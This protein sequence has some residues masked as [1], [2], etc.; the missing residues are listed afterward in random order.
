MPWNFRAG[1][2]WLFGFSLSPR[3]ARRA[4]DDELE[5]HLAERTDQF[6]RRGMSPDEARIEVA[7]RLG[8]PVADVR[9]ALRRSAERRRR[10]LSLADHLTALRADVSFAA[11]VLRRQPLFAAFVV[12]TL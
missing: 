9:L 7:K 12:T 11:R 10:R 3:D 4:A 5:A 2:R 1:V 6:T 8:A